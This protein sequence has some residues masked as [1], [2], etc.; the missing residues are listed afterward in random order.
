LSTRRT[1]SVNEIAREK[2]KAILVSAGGTTTLT[3]KSSS[4]NTVQ[5][6][7]DTW[8]Q[9]NVIGT[10]LV[11][12]G[13]RTWYFLTADYTFGYNLR[14]ETSKVVLAHGGEATVPGDQAF[15]SL[16]ESGCARAEVRRDYQELD[17]Q[18]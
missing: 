4:P 17:R 14:D 10:A 9:S 5:W 16:A 7:Y 18:D 6:T 13:H 12:A 3:G 11:K 1:A 2:N 15:L 8:S